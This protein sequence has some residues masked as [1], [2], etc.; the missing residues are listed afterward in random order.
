MK[1]TETYTDQAK[2]QPWSVHR[3]ITSAQGAR[4]QRPVAVEVKANGRRRL[5]PC[6]QRL[7]AERQCVACR[8]SAE[9]VEVRRITR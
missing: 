1:V 9:I 5:I 3:Q 8:T 7:P 6:G 4:C 2:D